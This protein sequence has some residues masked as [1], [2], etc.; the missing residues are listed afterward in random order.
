M[1]WARGLFR[2]WIVL[3]V[4]WIGGAGI[5]SAMMWNEAQFARSQWEKHQK[6]CGTEQNPKPGPWCDFRPVV[7]RPDP[8]ANWFYV[9][10][11]V[12]PPIL[13]FALGWTTLWVV[14]G[15]RTT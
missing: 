2:L 10:L 3:S 1:S 8:N 15:F 5:A 11:P 14:R 7:S 6:E 4:V 9:G 12:V 13:L